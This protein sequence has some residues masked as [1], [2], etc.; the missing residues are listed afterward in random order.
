MNHLPDRH[1]QGIEWILEG[2]VRV[3]LINFSEKRIY[4][5]LPRICQH[6]KLDPWRE[7]RNGYQ[8]Q[9]TQVMSLC[10]FTALSILQSTIISP[11]FILSLLL[12]K[13]KS[14]ERGQRNGSDYYVTQAETR[15]SVLALPLTSRLGIPQQKQCQAEDK[16]RQFSIICI[17]GVKY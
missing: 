10:I 8:G 9:R 12:H 6:H 4:S 15:L 16:L 2:K 5:S 14:I 7:A 17:K 1:F 13:A 11:V 3:N